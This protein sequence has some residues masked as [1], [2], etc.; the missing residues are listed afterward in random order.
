MN[1]TQKKISEMVLALAQH[2]EKEA[3][4]LFVKNYLIGLEEFQNVNWPLVHKHCL[5]GFN[6]MPTVK[7]IC[8]MLKPPKKEIGERQTGISL[9]LEI[10][11]GVR[12]FG[13]N[14]PDKARHELSDKAWFLVQKIGGW[15]RACGY[16][17]KDSSYHA[18]LRDMAEVIITQLHNDEL[19]IAILPAYEARGERLNP[20]S[21]ELGSDKKKTNRSDS[22][23][24]QAKDIS[25][26]E[27]PW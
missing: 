18:Q 4:S 9:I 25:M 6:R 14:N 1:A 12:M 26:D 23:L 3:D 8:E 22:G 16:R 27:I 24:V 10:E 13:Y 21:K 17:F 15:E 19:D 5:Q 20:F 2:F 11:E 7:Q